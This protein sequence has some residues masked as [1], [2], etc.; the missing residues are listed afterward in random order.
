MSMNVSIDRSADPLSI[1]LAISIDISSS[2]VV[3]VVQF[4]LRL[5]HLMRH[6]ALLRTSFSFLILLYCRAYIPLLNASTSGNGV[7]VSIVYRV[8]HLRHHNRINR[9][10]STRIFNHFLHL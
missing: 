1:T 7:A 5:F 6:I 8:L 9:S 2:H 10:E 4:L 3:D